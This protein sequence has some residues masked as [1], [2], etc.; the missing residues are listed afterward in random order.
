MTKFTRYNQSIDELGMAINGKL[1]KV[2]DD[3][4]Y[5]QGMRVKGN[6]DYF[7]DK[8]MSEENFPLIINF[9][10][11]ELVKIYHR[12]NKYL[13]IRESG[14]GF[15]KPDSLQMQDL[16]SSMRELYGND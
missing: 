6:F 3:R 10:H 11:D 7:Y 16:F 8:M 5:F 4:Y 14:E 2:R 13:F 9:S 12:D 1:Y 15:Y